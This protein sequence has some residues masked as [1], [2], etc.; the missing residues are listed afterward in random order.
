MGPGVLDLPVH[1]VA[2][3]GGRQGPDVGGRL[4]GVTDDEALHRR[5]ERLLEFV[6]DATVHDE[7]FGG[8]AALA[9]VLHPGLDADGDGSIEIR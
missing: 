6:V 3:L 4:H 2:A 7:A 1:V 9:V 8:N 5:G